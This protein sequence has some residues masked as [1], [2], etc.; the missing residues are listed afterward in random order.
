MFDNK[1]VRDYLNQVLRIK[2]LGQLKYFLGLTIA[3][4]YMLVKENIALI[5]F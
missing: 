3:K 2:D 4:A 5:F 1:V